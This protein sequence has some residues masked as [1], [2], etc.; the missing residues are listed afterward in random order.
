MP[1]NSSARDMSCL[2][3]KALGPKTGLRQSWRMSSFDGT[4]T[5]NTQN[6]IWESTI[7]TLR[8]QNEDTNF[9]MAISKMFIAVECL[10]S[11]AEQESTSTPQSKMQRLN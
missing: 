7:A 6:G 5:V 11:R 8:T 1:K 9:P 2:T 4:D 10:L 3:E